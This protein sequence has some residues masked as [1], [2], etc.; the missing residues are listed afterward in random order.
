MKTLTGEAVWSARGWTEGLPWP[1]F[2][3]PAG[4]LWWGYAGWARAGTDS[5]QELW[6]AREE[7]SH[8]GEGPDVHFRLTILTATWKMEGTKGGQLGL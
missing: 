6:R 3:W 1:W 8:A 5:T 2:A 4:E 7:L